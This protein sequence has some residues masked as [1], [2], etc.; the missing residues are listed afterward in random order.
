MLNQ[1]TRWDVASFGT[2]VI[3]GDLEPVV[4]IQDLP[5]YSFLGQQLMTSVTLPFLCT[6]S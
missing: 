4:G 5:I 1:P 2:F 3:L 6:F